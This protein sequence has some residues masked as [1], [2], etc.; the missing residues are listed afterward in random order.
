MAKYYI[1]NN[2]TLVYPLGVDPGD[3]YSH[4]CFSAI[5]IAVDYMAGGEPTLIDREVLVN[6]AN[7]R[8]ATPEDGKRFKVRI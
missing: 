3:L 2:N 7:A 8:E 4:P 6:S 5:V 1:H